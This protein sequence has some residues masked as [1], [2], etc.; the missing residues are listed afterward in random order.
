MN[1]PPHTT[2]QQEDGRFVVKV[3][4]DIAG[5]VSQDASGFWRAEDET[6]TLMGRLHT[7][8]QAAG[9]LAAWFIA[10]EE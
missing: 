10:D 5:W 6:G 3:S 1:P 9:F 2:E 4:D 7:R 8:E